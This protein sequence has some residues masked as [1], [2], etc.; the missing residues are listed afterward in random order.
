MTD[1]GAPQS[2][3]EFRILLDLLIREAGEAME[4]DPRQRGAIAARLRRDIDS[5][6]TSKREAE[7]ERIARFEEAAFEQR[8]GAQRSFPELKRLVLE[9]AR[10]IQAG[11]RHT[12][13]R[14][15]DAEFRLID[16]KARQFLAIGLDPA[17]VVH[18]GSP[19]R[20]LREHD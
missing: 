18:Q 16:Q 13:M 10:E 17:R 4:R 19:A 7:E 9:R 20:R 11:L 15:P 3:S 8:T 6:E 5:L 12:R 2:E 14:L 1:P